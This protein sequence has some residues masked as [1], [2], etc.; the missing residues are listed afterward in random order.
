MEPLRP[1]TSG[2][3]Q[4]GSGVAPGCAGRVPGVVPE[5]TPPRPEGPYRTQESHPGLDTPTASN[6]LLGQGAVGIGAQQVLQLTGVAGPH[7]DHPSLAV[8]VRVHQLRPL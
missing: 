8:R 3:T 7:L 4:S 2:V 1:D 6:L 5:V